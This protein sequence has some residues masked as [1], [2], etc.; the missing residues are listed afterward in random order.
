MRL[1]TLT[2]TACLSSI[3]ALH[4]VWGT[5]SAFPFENREMLADTVAGTSEAPR[6]SECFVVAGLLCCAAGLVADALPMAA[7]P[8]RIGVAA[9]A[10]VLA[11]RGALGV[12]GRTGSIV[13]WTPSDRFTSMDRRLYG[14]L[15]LILAAGCAQ[16]LID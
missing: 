1:T 13:P 11:L 6:A 7:T 3:A 4:G 9:L 8:R 16:S 12:L 2:T 14:P 5:G 15:C 10:S